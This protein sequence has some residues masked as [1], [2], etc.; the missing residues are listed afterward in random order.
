MWTKEGTYFEQAD[1]Q[2]K[3]ELV[4]TIL[5]S[6]GQS[7][8]FST[9]KS[10]NGELMSDLAFPLTSARQI[11]SDSDGKIDQYIISFE[12]KTDPSKV[13]NIELI[14]TFDYQLKQLL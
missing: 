14:G 12:I 8:S 13:R 3:N 5:D 11:D 10:I 1:V 4:L 9:V 2:F 6:D 7:K